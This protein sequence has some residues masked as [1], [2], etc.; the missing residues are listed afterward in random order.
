MQVSAKQVAEI[1]KLNDDGR[2]AQQWAKNGKLKAIK[3]SSKWVFEI[4]DV[5]QF[6]CE[7][8][9][10]QTLIG[11]R[12]ELAPNVRKDLADAEL[13]EFKL[14]V[15][16]GK[17][18]TRDEIDK[19]VEFLLLN[20]RNRLLGMGVKLAPHVIGLTEPYQAQSIIYDECYDTLLELSRMEDITDEVDN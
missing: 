20:T 18:Y 14:A 5:I 15:E 19:K 1:Y 3:V 2:S 11:D 13:K 16:K 8:G 6:G 7:N 4:D 10:I 17:Y 12:D 9:Y